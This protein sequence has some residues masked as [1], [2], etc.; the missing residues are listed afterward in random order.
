MLPNVT[1]SQRGDKTELRKSRMSDRVE[2][3]SEGG[4]V[5]SLVVKSR[6]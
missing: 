1:L 4:L 6:E 5:A 3:I 2:G